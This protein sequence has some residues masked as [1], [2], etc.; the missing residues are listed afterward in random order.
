VLTKARRA[1]APSGRFV[2]AFWCE[3]E[4]VPYHSLPRRILERYRE[5]PAP[6]LDAPG[7]FRFA[8]LERTKRDFEAAGLVI[9]H[10]EERSVRSSRP[11]RAT[12]S[13]IG[14]A[15]SGSRR[16]SRACRR[17]TNAPGAKSSSP[18]SKRSARTGGTASAA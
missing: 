1:L 2:A 18:S 12:K 9:D 16:C 14:F 5:V 10:V 8:D 4:R 7:V 11:K 6:D 15:P 3:P 17:T 13:S